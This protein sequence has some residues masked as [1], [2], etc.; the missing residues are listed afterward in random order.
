MGTVAYQYDATG[1]RFL[2]KREAEYEASP[3]ETKREIRGF[4]GFKST[5]EEADSRKFMED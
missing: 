5:A 3:T 4:R 1:E 2:L